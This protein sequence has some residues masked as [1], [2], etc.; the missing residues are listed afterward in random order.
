MS[1]LAPYIVDYLNVDLSSDYVSS[2]KNFKELQ[3]ELIK[4]FQG[5][6]II[7]DSSTE[8]VLILKIVHILRFSCKEILIKHQG[9][10]YS[11]YDEYFDPIIPDESII[12]PL[13]NFSFDIESIEV[14]AEETINV[15][16]NFHLDF[17]GSELIRYSNNIK[18]SKSLTLQGKREVI[19]MVFL[20]YLAYF[21][22]DSLYYQESEE[23]KK[24]RIF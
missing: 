4:N 9:N 8:L 16:E 19:P 13:K 21:H 7:I 22:T 17:F 3:D 24:V 14:V 10:L 1:N 23:S 12:K 18:K 11:L 5:Q 15:D 6:S 2:F 20:A